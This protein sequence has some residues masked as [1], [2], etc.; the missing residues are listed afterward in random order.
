MRHAA[1]CAACD[2]CVRVCYSLSVDRRAFLA[3]RPGGPGR[4]G[5]PVV[6]DVARIAADAVRA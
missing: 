2:V 4:A 5:L 3:D 1:S 6:A